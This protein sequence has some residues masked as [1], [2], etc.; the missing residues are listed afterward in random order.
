MFKN[1]NNSLIDWHQEKKEN[2]KHVSIFLF[3]DVNNTGGGT[4]KKGGSSGN[5]K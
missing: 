1:K 4:N 5:S 2:N 3:Q